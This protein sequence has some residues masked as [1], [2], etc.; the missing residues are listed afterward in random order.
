MYGGTYLKK[1][2]MYLQRKVVCLKKLV[3]RS[4]DPVA[5]WPPRGPH[6]PY[7][8]YGGHLNV[9]SKKKS[10]TFKRKL[11]E[12]TSNESFVLSLIWFF[13][14]YVRETVRPYGRTDVPKKNRDVPINESCPSQKVDGR[15]WPSRCC[16]TP[17]NPARPKKQ[18]SRVYVCKKKSCSIKVATPSNFRLKNFFRYVQPR[19]CWV[20]CRV[21]GYQPRQRGS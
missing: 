8:Q 14:T 11:S 13:C 3:K 18:V 20:I 17:T 1:N 5:A 16:L 2:L 7:E 9:P 19:L 6:G 4:V 15:K 10:H 12:M 21:W